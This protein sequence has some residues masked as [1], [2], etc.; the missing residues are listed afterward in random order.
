MWGSIVVVVAGVAVAHSGGGPG[1][2]GVAA[3]QP[4]QG[5]TGEREGGR[6]RWARC[7]DSHGGGAAVEVRV[8]LDMLMLIHVSFFRFFPFYCW[9]SFGVATLL[10]LFWCCYVPVWSC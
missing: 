7:Q 6:H 8:F 5:D 10:F 9:F 2:T 4:S 3:G 1:G